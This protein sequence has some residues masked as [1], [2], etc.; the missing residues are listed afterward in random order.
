MS[1]RCATFEGRTFLWLVANCFVLSNSALG[2]IKPGEP[3]VISIQADPAQLRKADNPIEAPPGHAILSSTFDAWVFVPKELKTQY[4][5][6]I[7]KLESLVHEID[8][9]TVDA[10]SATEELADLKSQLL[11]LRSR[12]DES[13]VR[14]GKAK[15]NEQ[16]ETLEF[17]LGEE[18]RLTIAA[19]QV[20]VIGW[21]QPQ[22]KAELRKIVL[23]SES[24]SET[25]TAESH[26]KDMKLVHKHERATFAGQ[27]D[28][29]WEAAE[30]KYIEGDGKSLT[31]EQLAKRKSVIE[32]I[33]QNQ[34]PHRN[35]VGKQ[36]DQLSVAGLDYQSNSILMTKVQSVGG[37]G[38]WGSERQRYAELTVYVPACKQVCVRGAKRGLIVEKLKA[39]LTILDEESTDSDPRSLFKVVELTGDLYCRDFP[40][41]EIAQ[42]QGNVVIQSQLEF[43]VEGAGMSHRGDFNDMHPSRIF[44]VSIN[45]VQGDLRLQYGRVRLK[46]QGITGLIDCEN[47]FGDTTLKIVDPL[48]SNSHRIVN[49]A[50]RIQVELSPQAWDETQVLAVTNFGGVR[51]NLPGEQFS[52]FMLSGAG[53]SAAHPLRRNWTGFRKTKND[54]N[55]IAALALLQRFPLIL[56]NKPRAAGLDLYSASGSIAVLQR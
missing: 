44:D 24:A 10:K 6:T 45:Q 27:T 53:P 46:M 15:L 47:L 51:T 37:E 28:E 3:Q 56:D 2:Q 19:N 20:R 48:T 35:Y 22:V 42:V 18:G 16:T 1:S 54:D 13:R 21:D 30:K 8:N 23:T 39:D 40:L 5:S 38:Q 12:I 9:G 11:L 17:N 41:R 52:N 7:N 43:G 55:A 50:G 25:Q 49:E 29:E 4:D 36:V 26:L 34:A 14:I 32:Q 33:R 31:P